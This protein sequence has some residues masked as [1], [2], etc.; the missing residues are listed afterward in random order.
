M[1]KFRPGPTIGEISGSIGCV[2][3]SHNRYGAYIRERV[4]PVNPSS[5]NQQKVRGYLATASSNWRALT[6]AMRLTWR[7][8]AATHTIIDKI[9]A[10][11]NLSPNAAYVQLASRL[12]LFGSALPTAAPIVDAP[13][14]LSSLVLEADIGAG[15]FDVTYTATPLGAGNALYIRAA[16][17]NS[18]SIQFDKNRLKFVGFSAAAQASPFDVKTLIENVFGT[19]QVG[20]IVV[21]QVAVMS[22]TTGLLSLPLR[23]QATVTTT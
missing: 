10:A 19:L 3:Y 23:A 4:I 1:A 7:N 18:A 20:Q 11:Q 8:W 9:G 15:D 2:T 21:V 12:L 17:L 22:T 13:T 6:A 14:G 16:V 5:P